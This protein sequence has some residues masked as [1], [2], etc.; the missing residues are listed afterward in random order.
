MRDHAPWVSSPDYT[1]RSRRSNEHDP[2]HEGSGLAEF[3]WD[4]S[5]GGKIRSQEPDLDDTKMNAFDIVSLLSLV[6]AASPMR[7]D[8]KANGVFARRAGGK[9][10]PRDPYGPKEDEEELGDQYRERTKE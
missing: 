10:G 1:T 6:P 2:T 7:V 4:K 9:F 8:G 5:S 3:R